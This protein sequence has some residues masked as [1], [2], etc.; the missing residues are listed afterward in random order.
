MDSFLNNE[1]LQELRQLL[2][3]RY[4]NWPIDTPSPPSDQHYQQ[5]DAFML[6]LQETIES[7]MGNPD[8]GTLELCKMMLIS[9]THLHMKV[10]AL[11]NHSTSHV[12]R[13]LRL[14]K[15]RKL[16][17]SAQFNVNEVAYEVGFKDPS[18]FTRRFKEEFGVTPGSL[19]K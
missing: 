18:Y 10:K 17:E 12:I 7:N 19:V 14:H 3:N 13:T 2:R 9:R 1:K 15:A 8:F 16:L 4:R 11:T 5:E 6:R